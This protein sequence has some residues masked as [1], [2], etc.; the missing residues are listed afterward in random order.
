MNVYEQ[1]EATKETIERGEAMVQHS[2]DYLELLEKY[3][4][5]E[6]LIM[7]YYAK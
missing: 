4:E 2:K 6:M 3:S 1:I 7:A 5:Y